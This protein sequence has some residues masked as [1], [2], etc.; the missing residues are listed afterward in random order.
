[1][2][3][4]KLA[5]RDAALMLEW[6][7]DPF[8]VENMKTDFRSRTLRDCE[9]FIEQAR[10]ASESLHLA[11]ADDRD[12]YMGTVSLKHIRDGAAEFG[13]TVRRS[14]MGKGF[15]RYGMAEM[16]RKGWEDLGLNR[17]WWCVDP[18][19]QRALRF[20]EKGGYSRCACPEQA[21]GYSA[22]ERERF[23]WFSA[24]PDTVMEGTGG[25]HS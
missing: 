21:A 5:R 22:E 24:E 2:K 14:A 6:M 3:L 8:V 15:A 20:Y 7:H 17:V 10:D 1:M 25:R 12:E 9:L 19:N 4:R 13:I 23:V 16:L 11:I 18:L